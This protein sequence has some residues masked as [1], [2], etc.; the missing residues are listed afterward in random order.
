M[1]ALE[2]ERLRNSLSMGEKQVAAMQGDLARIE[3]ERVRIQDRINA[4]RIALEALRGR[5]RII[6]AGGKAA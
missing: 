4:A 1:H 3:G 5:L 2:A 6:E